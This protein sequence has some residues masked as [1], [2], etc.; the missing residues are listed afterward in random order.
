[1][2]IGN[3]YYQRAYQQQKMKKIITGSVLII[4]FIILSAAAFAVNKEERIIVVDKNLNIKQIINY[5][6][7]DVQPKV[8]LEKESG[9]ELPYTES[10]EHHYLS[11][12]SGLNF[13]KTGIIYDRDKETISNLFSRLIYIFFKSLTG[14][15]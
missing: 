3:D 8:F 12:K 15:K 10:I 9:I 7:K 13:D 5:S 4:F 11:I 6:K 14:G 2:A 1:M